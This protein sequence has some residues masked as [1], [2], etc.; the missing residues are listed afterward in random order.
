[1]R[2]AA[3]GSDLTAFD[4]DSIFGLRALGRT[5]TALNKHPISA[6]SGSANG[7]L[8]KFVAIEEVAVQLTEEDDEAKGEFSLAEAANALIEAGL[9]GDPNVVS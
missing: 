3:T 8:K 7:I 2:R 9:T 6:S 1:M 5:Y 4:I